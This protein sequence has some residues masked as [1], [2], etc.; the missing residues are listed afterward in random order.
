MFEN[1]P[2]KDTSVETVLGIGYVKLQRQIDHSYSVKHNIVLSDAVLVR[3][4][5]VYQ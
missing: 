4:I 2:M 5:T 3:I 1:G